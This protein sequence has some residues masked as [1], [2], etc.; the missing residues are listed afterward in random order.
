MQ[1][2]KSKILLR[3]DATVLTCEC[4]K[5]RRRPYA[6][7]RKVPVYA[8]FVYALLDKQFVQK[9]RPYISKILLFSDVP[10]YLGNVISEGPSAAV[11]LNMFMVKP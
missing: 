3:F 4:P 2:R 6:A 5:F 7:M 9:T 10:F 8:Q 11:R 1:K